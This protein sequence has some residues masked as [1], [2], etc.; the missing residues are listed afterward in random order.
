M[1][2]AL[3]LGKVLSVKIYIHWTFIFLIGWIVISNLR[4]GL[5]LN[6]ILWSIGFTFAVFGC[7]VLHE[8]GHATTARKYNIITKYITLFPIGGIAQFEKMPESP[9]Q[10]LLISLAGPAVNVIIALLLYPFIKVQ[11]LLQSESM[12]SFGSTNFLV[13]LFTVNISLALFNLIPAFPMDGGRV[14]R[15]LLA[16]KMKREKATKVATGIGQVFGVAFFI[17]GF[18]YSPILIFIGLFIFFSGEYES[19]VIQTIKFLHKHTVSDVL[20][21]EVPTIENNASIKEAAQ[22]LLNTQNKNFVVTDNGKP[23]GTIN[24]DEIVKAISSK[25]EN[26][27]VGTIKNEKLFYVSEK[28]PLDEA[29]RMLQQEKMPLILVKT[30]DNLIGILEK[31][32]I[33]EFILLKSASANAN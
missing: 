23:V 25:G 31:E 11:L 29:W 22:M 5:G 13:L 8:L 20:M 30:N 1:K 21:R 18:L 16:F 6:A 26:A 10:E 14:L 24:R 4:A 27:L 19:S 7:I 33:A 3:Y 32:N 28:M 17:A 12:K 2:Y 15:A 9:K